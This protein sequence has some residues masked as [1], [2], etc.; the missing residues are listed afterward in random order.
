MDQFGECN[1][2]NSDLIAYPDLIKQMQ[3]WNTCRLKQTQNALHS[4][5]LPNIMALERVDHLQLR[6][7]YGQTKGGVPASLV[8]LRLY[9][10][11]LTSLESLEALGLDEFCH[12]AASCFPPAGFIEA[13]SLRVYIFMYTH[14]SMCLALLIARSLIQFG[15]WIFF[16]AM[17]PLLVHLPKEDLA[18][19]PSMWSVR[20]ITT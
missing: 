5:Q 15:A 14:S 1:N 13:C 12:A 3:L 4:G 10:F 18:A 8:E 20:W 19:R 2:P 7:L 6:E 11:I 16:V 17:P 9:C